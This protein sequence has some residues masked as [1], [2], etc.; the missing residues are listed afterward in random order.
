MAC[1][2][3]EGKRQN[4]SLAQGGQKSVAGWCM[5]HRTLHVHEQAAKTLS[6]MVFGSCQQSV[7]SKSVSCT[8][9]IQLPTL[10]AALRRAMLGMLSP[11]CMADG[12][13]SS[14]GADANLQDLERHH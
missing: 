14:R 12:D 4:L 5:Q 1:L 3:S 7:Q 8:Q 11:E 9:C 13:L 2:S 6:I 10:M